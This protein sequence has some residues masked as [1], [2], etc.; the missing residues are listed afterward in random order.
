MKKLAFIAL[1]A[2]ISVYFVGCGIGEDSHGD[3][4]PTPSSEDYS[5]L[6]ECQ[7]KEDKIKGCLLIGSDE[8][9]KFRIEIPMKN[10]EMNGVMRNYYGNTLCETKF[11]DSIPVSA[12][13]CFD[14]QGNPKNGVIK[15]YHENGNLAHEV[16]FKNGKIQGV[17]RAY[18][19]NGKPKGEIPY[20]NSKRDGVT[21]IYNEDGN[22]RAE[23]PYKDGKKD[24]VEKWY[25]ENGNL[26]RETPYKDGKIEGIK[27]EYD[28]NGNLK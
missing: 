22:L 7:N 21:K 1:C 12:T 18:H 13:L 19:T 20:K 28:E 10:N 15:E 11:V 26:W 8:S 25:Y 24:G 16:E 17:E 6:P 3:S 14:M 4:I 27:K 2:M 23:I 9:E 5:H